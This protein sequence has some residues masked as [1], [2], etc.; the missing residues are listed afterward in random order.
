MPEGKRGWTKVSEGDDD[1]EQ[2]PSSESSKPEDKPK[3]YHVRKD[4][5]REAAGV[6][7]FNRAEK[8]KASPEEVLASLPMMSRKEKKEIQ[9]VLQKEERDYAYERLERSQLLPQYE[10]S[11]EDER[12]PRATGSSSQMPVRPKATSPAGGYMERRKDIPKPVKDRMLAQFRKELCDNQTVKGKI[13]PSAG[14]PTPTSEQVRCPHPQDRL[15][16]SSNGDGHYAACRDCGLKHVIYFSERHGAW[17]AT[18]SSPKTEHEV[19]LSTAPGMAIMDSGCRSAVAGIRWHEEYQTQLK[20]LGLTWHEEPEEETFQFGSG[21]PEVSHRGYIYPVGIHGTSELIRMS[22]VGG[23]ASL[24]PGLVGP[25]EMARWNVVLSFADKKIQIK[26]TW[27]SMTLTSTRHPAVCLLD[28]GPKIEEFWTAEDIQD[29]LKMLQ[30]SPQTWAFA[31]DTE[32]NEETSNEA[33]EDEEEPEEEDDEV[34]ADE[35]AEEKGRLQEAL[36]RLEEDLTF[37]PVQETHRTSDYE[38]EWEI[39]S[40]KDDN[41]SITSHEFGVQQPEESSEEDESSQEETP[42]DGQG[43]K[44]KIK[45]HQKNNIIL[46]IKKKQN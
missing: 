15:R 1:E 7:T 22:C 27:K 46:G 16:W 34:S 20:R 4:L 23:G 40:D 31:A 14:A 32:K 19:F 9:K 5:L 33:S 12:D 11:S 26:G 37:L 42:E 43:I 21:A 44:K 28:F 6:A 45:M 39:V 30:R 13:R 8:V 38:E 36:T 25:S 24:C 2:I 29:S 17:V 3:M 10:S 41:E 18:T 35:E